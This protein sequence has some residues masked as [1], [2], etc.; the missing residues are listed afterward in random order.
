MEKKI[1]G[2][3]GPPQS[4]KTRINHVFPKYGIEFINLNIAG[5][6]MR[7]L[8][9]PARSFFDEVVLGHIFDNGIRRPSYYLDICQDPSKLK[10]IMAVEIPV[11]EE[12]ARQQI[13]EATGDV[14][15]SWEYLQLLS[16]EFQFDQVI[17]LSCADTNIW[18]TRLCSRA[19]ERGFSGRLS[20][21]EMKKIVKIHQFN[22]I[23]YESIK[24]WNDCLLIDS[25]SK[26]FGEEKLEVIL[27]KLK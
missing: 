20:N 16:P 22:E 13:A 4:G 18:F 26:D 1:Y 8:G 12:Y 7:S 9:S 14:I 11:I 24:R 19:N 10:A 23:I 17:L 6:Q 27:S 25:S 2:L 15:L 3:V 21:G 5:N